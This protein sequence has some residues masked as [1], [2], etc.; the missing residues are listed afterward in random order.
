MVASSQSTIAV[1][2]AG[3]IHGDEQVP[4]A[5]VAVHD[6]R[7]ARFGN[8][9]GQGRSDL[10]DQRQ[11]SC[12]VHL[13]EAHEPPH[14]ARE[15]SV[16]PADRLEP[17]GARRDLVQLDQGVDHVASEPRALLRVVDPR[18]QMRVE[19]EA[20]GERHQVER[21]AQDGGVCAHAQ[22]P[23]ARARRPGAGRRRSCSRA[24]CRGPTEAGAAAA[25]AAARTAGRR[26]RPGTSGW[27][28]R[29]RAA[30]RAPGP[31]RSRGRRRT[32]RPLR[33]R[34]APC[35]SKLQPSPDRYVSRIRRATTIRCTSSG[36][37]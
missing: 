31:S 16:G 12:P 25:V 26:A 27:S 37:S 32:P 28:G 6:R 7:R 36:P 9:G 23:P 29:H 19:G 15:I 18:W 10:G 8:R 11:I 20:A 22:A 35:Y 33:G 21:D 34:A 24:A 5:V 14:L 30:P 17:G 13:P 1:I 3:R 4:D 2:R